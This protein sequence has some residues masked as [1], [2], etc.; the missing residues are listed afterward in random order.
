MAGS[1]VPELRSCWSFMRLL[2]RFLI[3]IET[4]PGLSCTAAGYGIVNI[5]VVFF[6]D[7]VEVRLGI[8]ELLGVGSVV[9]AH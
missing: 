8:I 2:S 4:I 3:S 1:C 6:C 9:G 5:V 7:M